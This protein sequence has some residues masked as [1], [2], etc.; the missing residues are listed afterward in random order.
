[1]HG[2]RVFKM[3]PIHHHF[4]ILGWSEAK[5][6]YRFS[7]ITAFMVIIVVVLKIIGL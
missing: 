4:E 3:T 5:I 7:V 1:T 6:D 2:K